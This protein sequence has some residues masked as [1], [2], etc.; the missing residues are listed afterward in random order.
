MWYEPEVADEDESTVKELMKSFVEEPGRVADSVLDVG[1]VDG[2]PDGRV[3]ESDVT[4]L[5]VVVVVLLE[6]DV[7]ARTAMVKTVKTVKTVDR[8]QGGGDKTFMLCNECVCV[9]V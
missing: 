5:V 4:M 1:I 2:E 7:W 6:S 9:C 3:D 8:T